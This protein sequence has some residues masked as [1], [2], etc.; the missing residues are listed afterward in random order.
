MFSGNNYKNDKK[1]K[2]VRIRK[3]Y[4]YAFEKKN[5]DDDDLLGRF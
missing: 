2:V 4:V 3:S 1:K 5:I